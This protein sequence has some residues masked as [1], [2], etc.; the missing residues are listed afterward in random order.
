MKRMG[1]PILLKRALNRIGY[2]IKIHRPFYKTMI[3]PLG[4]KTVFD[5]GANNGV[6]ALEMAEY[7]PDAQIYAFEPLQECLARLQRIAERNSRI[8]PVPFA[9]GDAATTT[10]IEKSSFHPS[11]SLLRMTSLHETLYPR[12]KGSTQE[13]IE[14]RT[15]VELA[16]TL[17]TTGP[18]L[19]KID[20]QGYE[21]K[22]IAG[23]TE[24]IARAAALI[25]ETSF[26]P[27]YEGQPLFDEIAAQ[28]RK[29]GFRY[30]GAVHTHH[31]KKT[32]RALYEDSFF[33]H[34]RHVDSFL[35]QEQG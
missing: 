11:S 26:V 3:A 8:V 23:G 32:G 13:A 7:F 22:V 2:D 35:Q 19:I 5:I 24:T 1:L 21:G 15:L 12:S 25:I 10:L 28:V 14:V 34:E 27:L 30:R 4:I 9:L 33:V 29:L 17:A 31:S 16:P 20:V 6:Y 18:L